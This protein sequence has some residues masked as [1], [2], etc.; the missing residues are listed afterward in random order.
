MVVQLGNY[1]EPSETNGDPRYC[2]ELEELQGDLSDFI[3]DSRVHQ[4]FIFCEVNKLL[5]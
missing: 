3:N 2:L 5:F 4:V 1:W